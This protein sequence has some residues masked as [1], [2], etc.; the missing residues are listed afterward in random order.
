MPF[1]LR[2][3]NPDNTNNSLLAF[4]YTPKLPKDFQAY[5]QAKL[6]KYQKPSELKIMNCDN[7][8]QASSSPMNSKN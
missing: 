2:V 5:W 1:S 6:P 3:V 7:L 4:A 8:W